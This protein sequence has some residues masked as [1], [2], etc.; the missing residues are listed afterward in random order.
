MR[1]GVAHTF[2]SYDGD[3]GNRITAR[4]AAKV[5]PFFSR[6]LAAAKE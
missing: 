1:L 5:L 2:E 3:H 4:F 6:N